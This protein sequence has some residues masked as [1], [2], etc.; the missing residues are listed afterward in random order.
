MSMYG[1]VV[2]T[3]QGAHFQK[4]RESGRKMKIGA[5]IMLDI[6]KHRR[7]G[8]G[9]IKISLKLCRIHFYSRSKKPPVAIIHIFAW[10]FE[11]QI[12]RHGG[13][14]RGKERTAER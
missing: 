6:S 9:Y 5:K 7:N 12:G 2:P 14:K 3:K 8:V 11:V 4:N 1:I 13:D 10:F